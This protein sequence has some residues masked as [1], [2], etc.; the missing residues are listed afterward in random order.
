MSLSFFLESLLSMRLGLS[1]FRGSLLS[2][3]VGPHSTVHSTVQRSRHGAV[4]H[5]AYRSVSGAPSA[6]SAV[7]GTVE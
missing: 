4:R 3:R 2:M 5:V 1:L 7:S 6:R